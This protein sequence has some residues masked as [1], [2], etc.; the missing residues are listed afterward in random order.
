MDDNAVCCPKI[1]VGAWHNKIFDWQDKLFVKANVKTFF[2]IPLNFGKVI[3]KVITA[4]DEQKVKLIDCLCLSDHES[5]WNMAI[6]LAVDKK[7]EGFENV[8]LSGKF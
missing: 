1:D 6:Y 2:Y 5:K 3:T 7:L 8:N 4:A